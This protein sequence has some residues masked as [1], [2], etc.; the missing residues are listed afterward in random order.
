MFKDPGLSVENSWG[1]FLKTMGFLWSE[2]WS[3]EY[4]HCDIAWERFLKNW[5][6]WGLSTNPYHET[7]S[8]SQELGDILDWNDWIFC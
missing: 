2:C 6:I 3:W 1:Y 7:G 4:R 8:K 5:S